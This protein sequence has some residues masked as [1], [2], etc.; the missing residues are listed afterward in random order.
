MLVELETTSP[1]KH[2]RHSGFFTQLRKC[3]VQRVQDNVNFH[4][5]LQKLTVA[6]SSLLPL[7]AFQ[8]NI[9]TLCKTQMPAELGRPVT[10][11]GSFHESLESLFRFDRIRITRLCEIIQYAFLFSLFSIAVGYTI[12]KAF[13]HFYPIKGD[14]KDELSNMGQVIKTCV[15]L[16]LQVVV[17]ALAVFYVRKIINLVPPIINLAPSIYIKHYKVAESEGELAL[18]ICYIGI[19][20]NAIHELEKI[21]NYGTSKE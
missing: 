14:S 11:V 2:E 13:A 17:G 19:Q 12:D 7:R 16:A 6:T 10:S 21:R 8:S 20:A 18:A 15:T 4:A 3:S 5:T 9:A 1:K